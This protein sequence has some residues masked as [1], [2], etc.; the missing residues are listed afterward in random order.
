MGIRAGPH[1]ACWCSNCWAPGQTTLPEATSPPPA[2]LRVASFPASTATP[3]T[4]TTPVP[5]VP[6]CSPD[7]KVRAL[8]AEG[9]GEHRGSRLQ[10]EAVGLSSKQVPAIST[11][12]F[13]RPLTSDQITACKH[14]LRQAWFTESPNPHSLAGR[15]WGLASS[16]QTRPHPTNFCPSTALTLTSSD[17][18][19]PQE[20]RGGTSLW[21]LP[22]DHGTPNPALDLGGHSMNWQ[23]HC[24]FQGLCPLAAESLESGTNPPSSGKG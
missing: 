23:S 21:Q 12:P 10:A 7:Q 4:H 1:L 14:R 18:V 22:P 5:Q 19:R 17:W 13:P 24:T 11:A 8:V 6:I 9:V 20:R 2:W 15:G 3:A 16:S